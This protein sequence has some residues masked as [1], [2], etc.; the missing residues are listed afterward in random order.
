MMALE[1][2]VS[3]FVNAP[4]CSIR[5]GVAAAYNHSLYEN[6]T[7]FHGYIFMATV[8]VVTVAVHTI[9]EVKPESASLGHLFEWKLFFRFGSCPFWL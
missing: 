3:F 2:W 9:L 4:C 7:E 5:A 6:G 1:L 8:M